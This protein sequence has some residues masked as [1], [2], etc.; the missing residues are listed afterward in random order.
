MRSVA[1]AIVTPQHGVY[2]SNTGQ[3]MSQLVRPKEWHEMAWGVP[4]RLSIVLPKWISNRGVWWQ[5]L[6]EWQHS[7]AGAV[8]ILTQA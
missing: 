1:Q 5:A 3:A 4:S 8:L 2:W 6:L 7:S